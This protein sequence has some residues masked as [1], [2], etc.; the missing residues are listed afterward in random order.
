M[1]GVVLLFSLVAVVSAAESPNVVRTEEAFRL[2]ADKRPAS[3]TVWTA[4]DLGMI[5]DRKDDGLVLASLFDLAKHRQLLSPKTI[6]RPR[7]GLET[8]VRP[9]RRP[10]TQCELVD[11]A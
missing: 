6:D 7:R 2:P 3:W 1:L 4:G 11:F 5:L 8:G 9:S 10:K